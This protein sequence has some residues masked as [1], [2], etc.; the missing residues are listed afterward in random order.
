M[1]RAG[2]VVNDQEPGLVVCFENTG[3]KE[4]HLDSIAVPSPRLKLY[5]AADE[6]RR[7]S[8]E[9]AAYTAR[10]FG[11]TL[12]RQPPLEHSAS[13]EHPPSARR[14]SIVSGPAS[15]DS[16]PLSGRFTDVPPSSTDRRSRIATSAL[17]SRARCIRLG[18][19]T[20]NRESLDGGER[21][22]SVLSSG[23]CQSGTITHARYAVET[24]V[25]TIS[26]ALFPTASPRDSEY[27][28]VG[29]G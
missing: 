29:P 10:K 9:R 5:R 3:R 25:E 11:P 12:P 18:F 16:S 15:H 21:A 22:R 8:H 1:Q 17:T 13:A 2:Q 6:S 14:R 28:S 7:V 19:Q 24:A 23:Y 27:R 26:S 20:D 4:S